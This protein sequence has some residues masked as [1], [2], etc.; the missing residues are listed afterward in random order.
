[1]QTVL[2]HHG[3][4][5]C[6]VIGGRRWRMIRCH[7]RATGLHT[8]AHSQ[9][10]AK[11][12]WFHAPCCLGGLGLLCVIDDAALH[13]FSVCK[14]PCGWLQTLGLNGFLAQFGV[15]KLAMED[16]MNSHGVQPYSSHSSHRIVPLCRTG[17]EQ[18]QRTATSCED[19]FKVLEV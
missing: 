6:A 5:H 13:S 12:H 11:R 17:G 8:S 16:M 2:A 1:M 14:L 15:V 19:H 10:K 18:E 9:V 4:N 7:R 3:G